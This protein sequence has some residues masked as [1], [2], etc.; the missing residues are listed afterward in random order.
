MN[1]YALVPLLGVFAY[2]FLISL[3]LRNPRRAERRA[4]S[5]FLASAAIWSLA[6]FLLHLDFPIFR[7]Y[8]VT[9]SKVLT[10]AILWMAVTLYHFVRVFVQ[11][12]ARPGVFAGVGFILLVALLFGLGVA[13]IE[14]TASGGLI[15]IEYGPLLFLYLGGGISWWAQRSSPWYG[16]TK[17]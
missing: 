3:S 15:Y 6:S 13:P 10:L 8:A 4:F 9:G 1:I 14:A 12:P 5:L 2:V 11:K 7:E 17:R 16:I